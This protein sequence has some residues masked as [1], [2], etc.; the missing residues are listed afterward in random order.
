[1]YKI[2]LQENDV[3]LGKQLPLTHQAHS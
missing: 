2:A 3:E 1:M